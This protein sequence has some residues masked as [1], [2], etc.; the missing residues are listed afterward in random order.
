[1][2]M[3]AVNEFY[4]KYE[5]WLVLGLLSLAT[6]LLTYNITRPLVD[7]DEATYA[8]VMVDTVHS[9]DF[10]DLSYMGGHWFEKPPLYFWVDLPFVQAF[11]FNEATFRIPSIF[12][13]L[14]SLLFVYLITKKETGDSFAASISFL[15]LLSIP[16]FYF[17]NKEMRL[18]SAVTFS[19]LAALYV[20][21][22]RDRYKKVLIFLFPLIAIGF[23]F[24]SV[25]ALLTIPAIGLY[26]IIRSEW[27]WLTN[28]YLWIGLLIAIAI[29]LPWHLIETL[30]FG[31]TFWDQYMGQQIFHRAVTTITGTSGM[32]DYITNFWLYCLWWSVGALVCLGGYVLMGYLSNDRSRFFKLVSPPLSV[33]FFLLVLFSLARSHL[34]PYLI[35]A[36]AFFALFV[37]GLYHTI[38][39]EL[40]NEIDRYLLRGAFGFMICIGLLYCTLSPLFHP[41]QVYTLDEVSIGKMYKEDNLNHPAPLY[42]LGW[43]VH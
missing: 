11:G 19:I 26:C 37:G 42:T 15:T 16:F 22:L 4:R 32:F 30:R 13:A 36:F 29:W 41:E 39:W 14:L 40:K 5:F 17:Y 25:I 38:Y 10:I 24:K 28:K 2:R 1:M 34:T 12:F 21:S 23:L 27:E 35:P 33:A 18:D 31:A 3:W 8:K 6:I 43:P 9:G 7:Y 20:W